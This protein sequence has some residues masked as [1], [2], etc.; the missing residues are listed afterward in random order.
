M[1]VTRAAPASRALKVVI[2][3]LSLNTW[4]LG[5]LAKASPLYHAAYVSQCQHILS[6]VLTRD[7]GPEN[8]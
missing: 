1:V 3:Q 8:I 6:I 2:L 4:T 5:Y 7:I